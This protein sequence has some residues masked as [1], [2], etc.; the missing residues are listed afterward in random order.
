MTRS[1]RSRVSNGVSQAYVALMVLLGIILLLWGLSIV[2][3]WLSILIAVGWVCL[4]AALK[5]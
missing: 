5:S 2:P 1:W 4:F 3:L